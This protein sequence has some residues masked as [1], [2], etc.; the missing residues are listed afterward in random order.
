MITYLCGSIIYST[1]LKIVFNAFAKQGADN[2]V[3]YD[4]W[5][6][7]DTLSAVATMVGFPIIM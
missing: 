6:I 1:M 4:R 5:C 2:R 3:P 7:M